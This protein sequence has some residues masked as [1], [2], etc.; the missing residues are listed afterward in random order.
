MGLCATSPPPPPPNHPSLYT[1]PHPPPQAP[2]PR[3][4]MDTQYTHHGPKGGWVGGHDALTTRRT[5]HGK[6]QGEGYVP[7]L[8]A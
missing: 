4:G 1:T 3:E 8:G 2:V 5:E 6:G 7:Q